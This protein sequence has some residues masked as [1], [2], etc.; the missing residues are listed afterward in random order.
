MQQKISA[1]LDNLIWIGTGKFSLLVREYSYVA[2]NVL[3]SSP[4]I[5][6]LIKKNFFEVNLAQDDEKVG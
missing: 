1:F 6:Y 4:K 3:S 2:G 5:S